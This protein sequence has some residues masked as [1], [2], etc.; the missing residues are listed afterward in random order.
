MVRD[1]GFAACVTRMP[2]PIGRFAHRVSAVP[3]VVRRLH[4]LAR[5]YPPFYVYVPGS[6]L[7]AG[8]LETL[9]RNGFAEAY[10]LCLL[11]WQGSAVAEELD[12]VEGST[13]TVDLM[14]RSFF[15]SQT[16]SVRRALRA[17][18]TSAT[19]FRCL[20]VQRSGKLIAAFALYEHASS[21]GFYNLCVEPSLRRKGIGKACVSWAKQRADAKGEPLTLQCSASLAC[22]YGDQGFLI[23]DKVHVFVPE[24]PSL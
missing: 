24:K 2:H 12:I 9:R 5:D 20:G 19:E 8:S 17:V 10:E 13:E 22:W 7:T 16:D 18:Y 6:E 21:L 15:S 4:R 3:D 1:P 14:M 23:R 11:T